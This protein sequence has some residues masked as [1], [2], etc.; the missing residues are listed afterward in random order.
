MPRKVIPAAT[1]PSREAD[2]LRPD[3]LDGAASEVVLAESRTT[4]TTRVTL[5]DGRVFVRKQWRFPHARDRL[6]GVLR[7][8]VLAPSPAVRELRALERLRELP[9]GPRAPRPHHAVEWRRLGVLERCELVLDLVPDSEPLDE[10]LRAVTDPHLRRAV[11]DDLATATAAMHQAGLVDGDHHP[12]NVL[13]QQD[14]PRVWFI[15]S[16][17]Q[18]VGTRPSRTACAGDLGALDVG[19]YRLATRTERLRALRRYLVACGDPDAVRDWVL[20][21][22]RARLALEPREARR[23]G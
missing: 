23:L 11:L 19:L 1:R 6:R 12:R 4:R 16:R 3:A 7:T 17:K 14:P 8:T 9:D 18:R 20:T 2:R 10:F 15:D 21:V 22:R 5:D 13:V